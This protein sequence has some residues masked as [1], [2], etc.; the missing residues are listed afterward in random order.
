MSQTVTGPES[1]GPNTNSN[2]N[3]NTNPDSNRRT[4]IHIL[5]AFF[6]AAILSV[7]LV[8]APSCGRKMRDRQLAAIQRGVLADLK[9][10]ADRQAEFHKA[11]QFYTTD[12]WA[13]RITPKKVLYKFGFLTPSQ[14][15]AGRSD[16]RPELKDLDAL[17]KVGPN[18]EIEYSTFTK[19]E[20]IDFNKLSSFCQ[21]CTATA[22]SFKAIAAANLDDDLTLDVWTIDEKG[23]VSHV[24]DDFK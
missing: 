19:L 14:T 20:K 5:G 22:S 6:A 8:M 9:L 1:T 15:I 21:D 11:N 18:L 12:L 7:A 23:N 10:I 16:L 4:G 3:S 24:I 2:A 13:L 17:K